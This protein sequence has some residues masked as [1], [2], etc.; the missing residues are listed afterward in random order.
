MKRHTVAFIIAAMAIGMTVQAQQPQL[1]DGI[2]AVV[3]KTIIRYS[4][5]EQAYAQ[6]RLHQGMQNAQEERCALLENMLVNKMLVH[7]GMVDSVKVSDEQ[8]ESEVEHYLQA[9]TLQAGGKDKL[10][11][12]F[13]YS[14]DEL[15]DQ[16]FDILHDR[17]LS[18]QV[19]YELTEGVNVTPAEVTEFFA[20]YSADSLPDIPAQYEV[21]EIVIEPIISEAERDRVRDELNLLRERVL[22]GENFS[23]LAKLYSQDPG[24]ASKGGELGFFGRGRMVSE[25][26]AAAFALKPGEVSPIVETQYGFHIIQLIERRGNNINVRHILMQPKTSSDD[27]LRARITLDSLAQEIRKGSITFEDAAKRY[28][29]GVSKNQGGSVANPNDGSA[30]FDKETFNQLYPGIGIVAM[31]EGEISNA[32]AIT[33]S[34]NKQAYC[35]IKLAR[36]IPAHKVNLTDDY[37]RIFS[38]ALQA[39]KAKK[40][41]EWCNR[42]VKTTYVRLADEFKDCPG[43]HVNWTKGSPSN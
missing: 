40:V 17:Y 21:S 35:L 11:E 14:Y 6:V 33:T 36:K 2:A 30:R 16:Y 3:G 38:A 9:A 28:S 24:S 26:E 4:D 34:E 5:I 22:K 15:H 8:V 25:F 10:R 27:L 18:Q 13:N 39:A 19:E 32:T 20:Q 1:V 31:E 23:M 37:D 29:D 43:F 7:K 12:V 42:M 41:Y